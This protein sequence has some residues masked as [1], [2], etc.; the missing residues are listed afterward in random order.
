MNDRTRTLQR[1][2]AGE[3]DGPEEAA[4]RR[5]LADHPDWREELAAL[6]HLWQAV[7]AAGSAEPVRPLW[8]SVAE[9]LAA[10]RRPTSWTLPQR[11]LAVAA[12]AAGVLLGF[13]AA[14]RSALPTDDV[15]SADDH[16]TLADAITTL[17]AL[18]LELGD[19]DEEAGS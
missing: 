15:A 10:R 13:G 2:V 4:V 5:M 19:T 8:P 7:D 18:W 16:E 6:Q 14:E 9:A 3:L 11:G 12:M 1:Y 17:D